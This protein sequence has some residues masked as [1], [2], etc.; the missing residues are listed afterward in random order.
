MTGE[1]EHSETLTIT[2]E[3]NKHH[4]D[5]KAVG[6]GLLAIH[7]MISEVQSACEENEQILIK[8]RPFARGSLEVPLDLIV[9]GATILFQEYPLFQKIREVIT[10]YFDIKRRLRGQPIHVEDGNVIIIENS[11]VQVDHITLQC[12]NP[13]SEVSRKCAEAFHAIEEDPEI[14]AVRVSSNTSTEPLARVQRAE[15]PYFHPETPIGEK[16]LGQ[17]YEESRETLVIRQP[18]FEAELK[19]RFV[20]RGAKISAE[21]KDERFQKSVETG[22]ESFAAGDSLDVDLQRLQEYDPAVLTY[23]DKEYTITQVRKHNH[24]AEQGNLFE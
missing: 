1:Q 2:Y 17:R 8:A 22:R 9:F 11:R 4:A 21:V 19:W 16:N 24:R 14:K 13:S 15:F 7:S 3:S 18:A 12:L 5:A 6:A 20:W 23:V 10:Q